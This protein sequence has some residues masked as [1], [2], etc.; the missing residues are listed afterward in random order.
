MTSLDGAGFSISLLNM[1]ETGVKE[2]LIELLDASCNTTGWH[3]ISESA[4]S[5]AQ[6]PDESIEMPVS[7][8]S[9]PDLERCLDC[10]LEEVTRR[11][12]AGL[13]AVIAAES[14]VTK[15]DSVVGDGDCGPASKRGAEGKLIILHDSNGLWILIDSGRHTSVTHGIAISQHHDPADKH[16]I[17]GYGRHIRCPLCH[18]PEHLT[19]YF[20]LHAQEPT[21]VDAKFWNNALE[22]ALVP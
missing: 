17:V 15:Y 12:R 6:Q 18:I 4:L 2:S 22:A 8:K 11:L 14:E 21:S 1:V 10:N 7:V 19:Y 3:A 5:N 20:T 16:H 13:K 9:E